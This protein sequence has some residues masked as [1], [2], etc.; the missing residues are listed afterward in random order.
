MYIYT[1]MHVYIYIYIGMYKHIYIYIYTC[2]CIDIYICVHMYACRHFPLHNS[3]PAAPHPTNCRHTHNRN[4]HIHSIPLACLPPPQE[5]GG[6]PPDGEG[7]LASHTSLSHAGYVA[8]RPRPHCP[9]PS[10]E[11]DGGWARR[12]LQWG[13]DFPAS[14][15]PLD[16]CH[17]SP[18][19]SGEQNGTG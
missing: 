8:V 7:R 6:G 18:L 5:S 12:A 14:C 4:H 16:V 10:A 9:P 3:E 13:I 11:G 17:L 1:H 2:I 15:M 19:P